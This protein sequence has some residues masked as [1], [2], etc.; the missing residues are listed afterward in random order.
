MIIDAIVG[1]LMMILEGFLALL[2][3]FDFSGISDFGVP[4][5]DSLAA[6]GKV[7]PVAVLG[8]CM[9]AV[10]AV[11]VFIH[12]WRLVVYIYSLIPFKAT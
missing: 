7:F 12:A 9:L 5:G 4:L 2:P 11:W 8:G 6:A 1:I 3:T 10:I